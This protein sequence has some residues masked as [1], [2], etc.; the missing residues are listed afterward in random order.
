MNNENYV[1]Y[2]IEGLTSMLTDAML[3]NV[4]LQA[5]VRIGNETVE[6]QAKLIGKLRTDL[7]NTV[8]GVE[9][10]NRTLTERITQ[11]ES[12]EAEFNNVKHQ[13][14]HVDT[15]R[16]ELIKERDLHQRT[17]ESYDK[18]ILELRGSYDQQIL[19]LNK[20]IE[21]LQLTPAKRKKVDEVMANST[22]ILVTNTTTEDGGSF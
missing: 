14:Q 13:V 8:K 17:R 15:F 19:E 12:K 10:N 16:N 1:N 6:E 2:Y 21:Y 18:Q 7:E 3:K 9:D 4:S 11:L 5:S 22:P 20:R